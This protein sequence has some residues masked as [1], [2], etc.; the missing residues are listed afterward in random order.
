LV[1]LGLMLHDTSCNYF[2]TVEVRSLDAWQWQYSET[3]LRSDVT[4]DY[5]SGY[6]SD[7]ICKKWLAGTLDPVFGYP[8]V[9]RFSWGP[10]KTL[11]EN[12]LLR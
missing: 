8:D 2:L 11:L 1:Y 12:V 9:V 3:L 4:K 10:T 5:G 7:P 6:P